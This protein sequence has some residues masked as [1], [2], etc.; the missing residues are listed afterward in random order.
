MSVVNSRGIRAVVT[1][2]L[3]ALAM[4]VAPPSPAHA[5]TSINV[6]IRPLTGSTTVI[7]TLND[8][9]VLDLKVS[10]ESALGMPV[11]DQR[12][13]YAGRQLE[14]ART[15]NSYNIMDGS[16]INLVRRTRTSSSGSEP[17]P[18]GPKPWFQAYGRPELSS[19]CLPGWYGSWAQWPNGSTGG[20]TCERMLMP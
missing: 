8:A 16:T 6:V 17:E 2:A 10:I 14:D 9:L 3:L 1:A 4:L 13:I 15:L 19:Q 20:W 5:S 18:E 12:L 7:G 11:A